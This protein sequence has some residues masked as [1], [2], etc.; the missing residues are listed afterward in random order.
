MDKNNLYYLVTK[1]TN[2]RSL[3]KNKQPLIM[4]SGAA[5]EEIQGW[6]PMSEKI[7]IADYEKKFVDQE[8]E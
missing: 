1:G 5:D 8:A 2:D 3:T 4:E 6:A 7:S